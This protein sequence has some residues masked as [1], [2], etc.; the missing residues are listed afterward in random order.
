MYAELDGSAGEKITIAS[1]RVAIADLGRSDRS[2]LM[3]SD[4]TLELI[5]AS[6][7]TGDD[8]VQI[9]MI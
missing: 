7:S 5:A 4:I 8:E 3:V 2:G 6:V 1:P 9:A